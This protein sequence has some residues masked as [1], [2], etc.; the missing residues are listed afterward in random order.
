MQYIRQAND[1]FRY[2]FNNYNDN[3]Q[4]SVRSEDQKQEGFFAHFQTAGYSDFINDS[5]I[6]FI[7][8]MDPSDCTKCEHFYIDTFKTF[9]F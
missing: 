1:K 2:R 7:N 9:I 3:N 4:K 6:R 5:D 8:E